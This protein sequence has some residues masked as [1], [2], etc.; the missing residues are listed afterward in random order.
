MNCCDYGC[1][2]SPNCPA[3]IAP[4]QPPNP[5]RFYLPFFSRFLAW[6]KDMFDLF[7]RA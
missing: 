6:A 7:R 3:R 2:Q 4:C 5:E 1:N